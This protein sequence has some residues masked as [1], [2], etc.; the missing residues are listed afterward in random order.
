VW[1]APTACW[2]LSY[3]LSVSLRHFSHELFVFGRH[4]D[5]VCLALGKSYLAY[6]ST[7]FVSTMVNLVL[8]WG[9]SCKPD[10]ALIFTASFSVLWSYVMLQQTWRTGGDDQR[11]S[12][13]DGYQQ[14]PVSSAASQELTEAP[15]VPAATESPSSSRRSAPLEADTV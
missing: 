11:P 8:V 10:M 5:P 1:W 15:D 7:I 9:A 12:T 6:L 4:A 2:T 14:L 13:E 3:T